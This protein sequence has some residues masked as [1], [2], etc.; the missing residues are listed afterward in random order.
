MDHNYMTCSTLFLYIAD[1]KTI[2]NYSRS[3]R[4]VFSGREER[5]VGIGNLKNIHA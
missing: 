3:F 4:P 2:I 1:Y 5:E